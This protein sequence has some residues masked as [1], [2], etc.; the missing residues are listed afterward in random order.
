VTYYAFLLLGMVLL[1]PFIVY[2]NSDI[3]FLSFVMYYLVLLSFVFFH[4]F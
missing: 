2:L 3:T 1:L 4:F